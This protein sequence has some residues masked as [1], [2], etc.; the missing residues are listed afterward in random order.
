MTTETQNL[1]E[2]VCRDV[3]KNRFGFYEIAQKPTA[4]FLS[5]FYAQK[6]YQREEG[7]YHQAYEQD[8]LDYIENKIAQKYLILEKHFKSTPGQTPRLL[9]V[10]CGE[11]WTLKYFKEKGWDVLGV[12]FSTF[13]CTTHN[14]GCLDNLKAGNIYELLDELTASDE[15]FS[16]IWLDNVL[17]HV[18]DPFDLMQRCRKLAQK[19]GMLIIEVPNDFSPTQKYLEENGYISR[20]SWV[21]PPDHLSYFNKEGLEA[22]CQEAGWAHRVTL[23]DYCIDFHLFNPNTNYVENPSVGRSCHQNRITIENLLHMISPEKTNELYKILA[24]MGLGRQLIGFFQAE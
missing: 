10:G 14:P 6:Y 11:G 5:R 24:D 23:G 4:E 13:G 3:V 22:L 1:A 21:Q 7:V 17:E 18:I 19:G 9:D 16:C 2:T 12:D 20:Q 8:E 15:K